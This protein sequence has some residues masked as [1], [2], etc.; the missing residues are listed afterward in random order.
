[1]FSKKRLGPVDQ[2]RT[3][4]ISLSAHQG[5]SVLI[6]DTPEADR[7]AAAVGSERTNRRRRTPS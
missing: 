4:P 5:M 2:W 3:F 6:V 7:F 1:M